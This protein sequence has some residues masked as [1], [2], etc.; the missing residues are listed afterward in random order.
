MKPEK[1]APT[2]DPELAKLVNA[3]DADA[4]EFYE[5]RAGIREH[6]GSVL[7][8]QAETQAWTETVAYLKRR[9]SQQ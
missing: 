5:E 2:L 1:Y 3:L 4:R 7:R 8:A 6:E 9:S